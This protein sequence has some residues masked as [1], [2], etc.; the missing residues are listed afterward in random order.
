MKTQIT[1]AA[2]GAGL[3]LLARTKFLAFTLSAIAVL[4]W[5]GTVLG[6]GQYLKVEYPPSKVPGEMILGV[7]YTLWIPDG[8]KTFRGV[9]VHQHGAGLTASKEGSTAAYDLQWQALAKKWDCALLGP[10][11]HV[12]N[13]GDMGAAGSEF[14]FD[15]R[16][17]SAKTFLK[18]LDD[19]AAKSGH[20]ELAKVPWALWGHSAGA[21]WA[22]LMATLYPERIVG[23][24]YRSGCVLVWT[25]PTHSEYPPVPIPANAT[26]YGVPRMCTGGAT[27]KWLQPLYQTTF[28]EYRS[29]GGPIG[30]AYEP[31]SGHEC[32]FSRYFAIPF[33][34]ACLAMRLPDKG[35][36]DQTLKPVDRSK[37]WLVAPGGDTPVPAADYKGKIEEAWWLPNEAVAKDW[38]E[39]TKTASVSDT[40]PPPAP[41]D[42]KVTPK[43]DQGT[44]I[45]WDAE[46]DLE[47]GIRQFIILRDGKEF[48][49]VPE[50]P[51]G[52][53]GRPLFQSMTYHDTPIQPMPQMAYVDAT[54]K[55]GD[56]HTY[57]VVTINSVGLESKPSG[58]K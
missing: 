18:C 19:F 45:T 28:Q 3:H 4:G 13:D 38:V 40:T 12:L 11:Y 39:Y 32:A 10:C 49:R 54:A 56:N 35:S 53:Y 15:P 48:A 47:S 1:N 52:K 14:W 30:C 55:A 51:K 6:A 37:A 16:R 9:I 22:D 42:L 24:Y 33:L 58:V 31:R 20:P 43:G 41:F 29:N 36:K 2:A 8:V 50:T 57:A 26:C 21:G 7:T 5:A 44:E 17:G 46:A 25:G 27:E 23:V 34:D